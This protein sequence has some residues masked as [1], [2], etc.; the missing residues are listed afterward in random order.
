MNRGTSQWDHPGTN[1]MRTGFTT[2]RAVKT[3]VILRIL[4]SL[5]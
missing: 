1:L 2:H 4:T 3:K 5:S